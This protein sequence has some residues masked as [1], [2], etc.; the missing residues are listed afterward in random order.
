MAAAVPHFGMAFTRCFSNYRADTSDYPIEQDFTNGLAQY[1][2]G[3]QQRLINPPS[4]GLGDPP[5][6]GTI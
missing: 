5:V 4:N 6:P 2:E 1:I 3:L